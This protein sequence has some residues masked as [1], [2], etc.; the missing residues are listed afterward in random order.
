MNNLYIPK[1]EIIKQKQIAEQLREFC[2]GKK[3][4]VQT[5]GCQQN[6]ADS[7]RIIGA[8]QLCGYEITEDTGNA[9]LVII[10]TCAVREHAELK[11]LSKTGQL[12]KQKEKNRNLLI[13]I[14]GCMIQEKHRREQIKRSYPYVDFVFGTDMHHRI[15][16]IIKTAVNSAK[17]VSF[18]TEKKHNEFGVISEDMPVS[19]QNDY[20]AWVS[21]MYGCD[22]FC[23]YCVVPYVRGRERSRPYD[24]IITE[25]TDLVNKGY[26]DITL[27][28]QN[29]N[30]YNGEKD[31]PQL[32]KSIVEIEGDFWI[33][34]MTSH[35][36]D[37]SS[38]LVDIMSENHKIA[39]HFHLP[40]QAGNDRILS[41]MR[42]GYSKQQYIEKALEIKE[43]VKD[44]AI[45]TDV[46]CGFPTESDA[47]FLDTLD[48]IKTVGFDMIYTF[49]YSPRVGTPAALMKGQIP[50]EEKVRR[51]NMLT[52]LQN[53]NALVNNKRYIGKKLKVLSDGQEKGVF[54]GRSSQNKIVALDKP[55]DKGRFVEAVIKNAQPYALIGKLVK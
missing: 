48:V 27:L 55:V 32:L 52:E 43:K 49:I 37:A 13:G 44:V 46:I 8:L 18:I 1:S 26:K 9:D 31:F 25:I 2:L 41:L 23:S 6:E 51:F 14:C 39:D 7:E 53:E 21:I 47:D 54:V 11:V 3:A 12:K 15:P 40:F 16:E 24:N 34:F 22:N 4:V 50:H 36:K 38:D 10:N 29:V 45:T 30:S 33:R 17:R 5:Y 20:K 42:R 28:G 19:R 35:P